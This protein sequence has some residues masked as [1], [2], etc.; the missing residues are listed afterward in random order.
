MDGNAT[1]T[2][3][4]N[5]LPY[6]IRGLSNNETFYFY[7][8]G[9]GFYQNGVNHLTAWDSSPY[10]LSGTTMSLNDILLEPLENS[11][12]TKSLIFIDACSSNLDSAIVRRDLEVTRK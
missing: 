9:H 2:A 8:A 6:Y 10:N 12:C 1:K 11:K 5:D 7:Y 3:I 4:E